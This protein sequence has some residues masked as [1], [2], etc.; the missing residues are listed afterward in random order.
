[1]GRADDATRQVGWVEQMAVRTERRKECRHL[2]TTQRNK[3]RRTPLPP[4]PAAIAVLRGRVRR[5]CVLRC[6][7]YIYVAQYIRRVV[8]GRVRR[9][10]AEATP[11][12]PGAVRRRFFSD[13]MDI[14]T[15]W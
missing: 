6:V 14:L 12:S 13:I 3:N 9:R 2:R 5:R 10:R 1:M 4:A 15:S 7:T 11:P 8:R